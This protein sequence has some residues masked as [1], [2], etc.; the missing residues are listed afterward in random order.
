[1]VALCDCFM[2]TGVICTKQATH[3]VSCDDAADF[4]PTPACDLHTTTLLAGLR[5]KGTS[6]PIPP[7]PVDVDYWR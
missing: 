1:M 7:E 4:T 3:I 5:G 6:T 2:L